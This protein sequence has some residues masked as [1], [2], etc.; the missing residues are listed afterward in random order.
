MGMPPGMLPQARAAAANSACTSDRSS[1]G[2]CF[3][4]NVWTAASV[5]AFSRLDFRAIETRGEIAARPQ[6][7]GSSQAQALDFV[8]AAEHVLAEPRRHWWRRRVPSRPSRSGGPQ[9]F[10]GGAGG[11]IPI[12]DRH[13]R[14]SGGSRFPRVRVI[15]AIS[16][17]SLC[18]QSDSANWSIRTPQREFGI[19]DVDQNFL[20]DKNSLVL[21]RDA[22][23]TRACLPGG[24]AP[25]RRRRRRARWR[26]R[27]H[28]CSTLPWWRGGS[29]ASG[30]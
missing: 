11:A 27:P 17:S 3:D 5:P 30:F 15:D 25:S 20:G 6:S 28:S 10:R 9:A 26:R 16:A 19:V 21:E 23:Q 2:A 29:T 22:Q 4:G 1:A 12:R 18:P 8:G 24:R 7:A 14:G 13:C